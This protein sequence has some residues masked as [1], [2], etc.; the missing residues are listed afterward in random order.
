MQEVKFNL[1]TIT[2]L[3]LAGADQT[4]AELRAPSFRGEMRYWLRALVGGLVGTSGEGL[5]RVRDTETNVFGATDKGSAVQIRV[6][7][8]P[9]R[10]EEFKRESRGRDV[11][12]RDYLLWSME[13]FRDKPRRRY[14][15]QGTKFQV[16]LSTRDQD[17]I[18]LIQGLA[19]FWLLTHLGGIGSRSRR[20]AGSLH[21]IG[22]STLLPFSTPETPQTLQE[23][24]T[25]GIQ[26]ARSLYR[27]QANPIRDALFD[28]LSQT[29][30]RIWILRESKQPWSTADEAIQQ[31]GESLQDYRSMIEP[32]SNRK[33]FGLPLK[34][35]DMRTRRA[36]PLLLRVTKLQGEQF[37]GIAV[38]FKSKAEGISMSDYALIEK[39]VA[40]DFPEALEVRL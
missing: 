1:Q 33:I 30:C 5:T 32:L 34:D 10:L 21:A 40:Q 24:L 39:W 36:S 3:F 18:H 27:L 8:S 4:T 23:Q 7:G 19:A 15:P 17:D 37:V 13:Q 14:F 31:I 25:R 38:L 20:C 16:T 6:L 9:I 28:A 2:P 11:T 35:V 22:D 12:G 29:T 26:T